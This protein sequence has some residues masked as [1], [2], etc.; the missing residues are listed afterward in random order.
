MEKLLGIYVRRIRTGPA[1][2]SERSLVAYQK[3][4]DADFRQMRVW[5]NGAHGFFDRS[6]EYLD[7]HGVL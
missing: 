1:S 5:N 2:T 4:I 7:G 3:F 6:E